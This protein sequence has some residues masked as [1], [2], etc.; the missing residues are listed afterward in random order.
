MPLLMGGPRVQVTPIA[1][2]SAGNAT[3]VSSSS[4][5]LLLDC[6]LSAK[7]LRRAMRAL[8]NVGAVLLTHEHADHSRG[9]AALMNAG[10]D[11][12]A[13]A[14]TFE[15]L[16]LDVHHRA[17]VVDVEVPFT[18]GP[19]SVVPLPAVHNA[20]DPVSWYFGT[21]ENVLLYAVDTAYVPYRLTGLTHVMVEA[22]WC[23][24]ILQ[25][26]VT[27]GALSADLAGSVAQNHMSI[28][29][30]LALLEAND[31]RAV[32]G[33]WLMHLSDGNSDAEAFAQRVAA[34]TGKPVRVAPRNQERS[35]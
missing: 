7:R 24:R 4:G 28:E 6:G 35:A 19:W 10:V 32:Q 11:V 27:G 31:L 14:G 20:A 29:G 9:A 30:A 8:T 23:P 17:R 15:A 13:T 2:S 33:I 26:R 25:Q 12:Y 22:N 3:V 5:N 18:I 16:G 21:A 34:A 1:S